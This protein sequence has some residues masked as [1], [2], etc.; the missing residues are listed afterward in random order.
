MGVIVELHHDE[1]GIIWP[2][3][4]APFAVHLLDLTKTEDEKK[5]ATKLYN[6]LVRA[7][8]EVLFDD[9]DIA[10][11][12]KFADADLLGMPARVV[13]SAKTLANNQVE[14]KNRQ[15]GEMTMLALDEAVKHFSQ[16]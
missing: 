7:G 3:S 11:G 15:S 12:A 9:R 6:D 2:E 8:V 13:V 1:R 10:A 5:Q 16:S 4:V 14:V